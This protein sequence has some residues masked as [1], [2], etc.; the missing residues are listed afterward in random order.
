[1]RGMYQFI[2][3]IVSLILVIGD[4]GI[5]GNVRFNLL[6]NAFESSSFVGY[7]LLQ[8]KQTIRKHY[9]HYI[10]HD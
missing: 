4:I 7:I 8:T 6:F 1:M 10:I 2:G 9:I 3:F 5:I